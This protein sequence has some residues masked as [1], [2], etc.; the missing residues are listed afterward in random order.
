MPFMPPATPARH[1]W[2]GLVLLALGCLATLPPRAEGGGPQEGAARPPLASTLK[3]VAFMSGHWVGGEAGDLSE[4]VWTAPEGDSMLGM[5]R[6]VAKGKTR[7]YEI[8]TLTAEGDQVVLSIRHFNPK[9]VA[10]E[11]KERSV[12][13]PLVAKGPGEA[14]FEGPEYNVKGAVR[15]TY[16][17]PTPDTLVGVLEKEGTRQEFSFRRRR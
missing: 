10:R 9:L 15:L 6:F 14:V 16:R 1:E 4:E 11:E 7:I 17:Q 2:A 3:D 12:E 5:W 8:L 13:L